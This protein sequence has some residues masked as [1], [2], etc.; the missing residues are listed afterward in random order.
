[1]VGLLVGS[2][3]SRLHLARIGRHGSKRGLPLRNEGGEG[4]H[5]SLLHRGKCSSGSS[6]SSLNILPF[7][8]CMIINVN[9]INVLLLWRRNGHASGLGSQD[10]SNLLLFRH[11]SVRNRVAPVLTVVW[12]LVVV[13]T[14]LFVQSAH[15]FK[16]LAI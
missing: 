11:I 1:M 16:M 7:T 8:Y 14:R 6:I 3:T 13:L 2:L 5:P 4:P 9:V 12:F 15:S 10:L